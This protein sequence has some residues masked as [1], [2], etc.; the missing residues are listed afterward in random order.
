MFKEMIKK[1]KEFAEPIVKKGKELA[2]PYLREGATALDKA[3]EAVRTKY[4][5]SKASAKDSSTGKSIKTELMTPENEVGPVKKKSL[6]KS[7]KKA[8][9][10]AGAGYLG[11][12]A[13]EADDENKKRLEEE[14]MKY[15]ARY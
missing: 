9:L 6:L 2:E 8:G 14:R 11:M 15:G 5:K 1:G 3:K 7:A 4:I 12:K 13:V 10:I